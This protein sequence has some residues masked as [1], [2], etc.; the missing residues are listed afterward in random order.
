MYVCTQGKRDDK[1]CLPAKRTIKFSSDYFKLPMI[2]KKAKL[3]LVI[4]T[5]RVKLPDCFIHYDSYKFMPFRSMASSSNYYPIPKGDLL[6][7]LFQADSRLEE[8]FEIFT[9]LRRWTKDKE[10]YYRSH[11]GEWFKVEVIR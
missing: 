4:K 3:L 9:T 5:T 2:V 10:Q 7:L 8:R 11:I 1:M 6:L